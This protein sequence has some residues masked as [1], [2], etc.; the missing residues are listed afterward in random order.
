MR[1]MPMLMVAL[2]MTWPAGAHDP[3]DAT[4]LGNE[5]ILVARGDTKILFDAFYAESFDGQY[6]LVPDA[7]EAKMMKG[8]APF[9]GVDAIFISHIHPDHFN[10]RKT[11]AYMRAH[12]KVRLYAGIDVVGAIRAADA[13]S[14]PL[15]QRVTQVHAVP[16]SSPPKFDVD[17]L[18]VEA[19]PIPHSGDGP[20]P[21]YA[22]RVTIDGAA[23]VMHLGDAD[24]EDRHYAPYQQD[25]DAKRTDA[26]FPPYW[27]LTSESGK[28]V[29]RQRI[30]A[31]KTIGIHVDAKERRR[32]DQARRDLGA[33]LF[34]EPGETRVIAEQPR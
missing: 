22:F 29:L 10:S 5:G 6:T 28:R 24:D 33:D 32:P 13:S 17:G 1:V 16:G 15:M 14:D 11:I 34:I 31:A 2:A 4:Y 19:F 26:A 27:M 23:T 7:L 9:D 25:F 21:N 3:A 8:E 30:R 12:P 20:T 18:A